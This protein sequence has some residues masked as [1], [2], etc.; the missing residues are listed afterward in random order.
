MK[1]FLITA[2]TRLSIFIL[3]VGLG[4]ASYLIVE[5]LGA[6][7]AEDS[8]ASI[9]YLPVSYQQDIVLDAEAH[10]LARTESPVDLASDALGIFY[11]LQRDGKIIRVAPEVGGETS[12]TPYAELADANFENE[13]G[14]SSLA[15]HPGFLVKESP[16]YG[17]FYAVIAEKSGVGLADF[18]PEFGGGAEHHQDVVYEYTVEDPL[19]SA[20]R[21]Q[22][23][24]MVRFSQPGKENNVSSLAFDHRGLLYL[25]VG[26]GDAGATGEDRPSRNA[27]TLSTAFGKVLRIDPVGRDSANGRYGIPDGN[28]FRLVTGALPELWAFG[29]RAPHNLS[30]DP[31]NRSLCIAESGSNGKDEINLSVIGGEHFGWDLDEESSNMSTA[32]RVQLAEIMT[33]PTV[34]MNRQNGFAA[35]TTGSVVYRGENFPSLAGRIVFASHDGQLVAAR[36]DDLNAPPV[37]LA[38]LEIGRLEEEKFSALRTGPRGELVVLCED[39]NVYEFRKGASLGTGGSKSRSLFCL[40]EAA[41]SPRG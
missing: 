24:E 28:P 15:I 13:I 38:R 14:C 35:R 9:S 11:I 6:G 21:G 3:S 31:F 23:R 30:F 17:R 5:G 4:V 27:S 41:T 29:L 37:E 1:K 7:Q 16:G 20:F 26:D 34:A 8:R 22:R 19:L 32:M 33:P 2:I 10:L 25:G 36:H 40:I 12:A 18:S 39:G